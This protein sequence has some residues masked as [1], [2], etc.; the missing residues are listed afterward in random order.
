MSPRPKSE[1]SKQLRFE[2]RMG[3][4]TAE[5]LMYCAEKLGVSRAAI[6]EKGIDLVKAELDKK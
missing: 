4:E 1:H 5:K 3:A 6:I 2:M